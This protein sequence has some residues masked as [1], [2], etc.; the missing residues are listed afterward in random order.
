MELW[1]ASRASGLRFRLLV[2]QMLCADHAVTHSSL[3]CERLRAAG[4]SV[5][6]LIAH[7][8]FQPRALVNSSS[9]P[10]FNHVPSEKL[11]HAQGLQSQLPEGRTLPDCPVQR[12]PHKDGPGQFPS[13]LETWILGSLEVLP[14][15]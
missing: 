15:A 8:L 1:E 4:L 13:F 11:P 3:V 10:R 12:I 7:H 5:S 2:F 9:W 6:S 14:A